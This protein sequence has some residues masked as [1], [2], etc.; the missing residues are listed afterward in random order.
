MLFLRHDKGE[1]PTPG[2]ALPG[3]G[4]P[5]AGIGPHLVLGTP[6]TP[7]FPDGFGTIVVGMGCFW[8]ADRRF[9]FVSP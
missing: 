3:R 9:G 6:I 2:T 4:R 8:G 7:P 5:M 1:L